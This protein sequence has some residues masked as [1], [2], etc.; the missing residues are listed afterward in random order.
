MSGIYGDF[1]FDSGP[2]AITLGLLGRHSA[3]TMLPYICDISFGS[4]GS[5]EAAKI[6]SREVKSGFAK[7]VPVFRE[8]T[9]R[10]KH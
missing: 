2:T 4:L 3:L 5:K 10:L 9:A 7:P 6:S 8:G 1:G